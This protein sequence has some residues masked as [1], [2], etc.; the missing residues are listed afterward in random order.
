MNTE[1]IIIAEQAKALFKAER[2]VEALEDAMRRIHLKLICV[3]GPLNDNV[4]GYSEEQLK[5]F[6]A[7]S[8]I[9]HEIE[10]D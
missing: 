8:N 3:G 7:I 1:T 2:R 9:V 6:R 4:L 10:P 5:P